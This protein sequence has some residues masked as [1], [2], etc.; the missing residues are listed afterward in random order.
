MVCFNPR[1]REERR[2]KRDDLLRATERDLERIAA[3]V[4]AGTLSGKARIGRRVGRGA[5]RWKVEKHFE[6][7]IGD[8]CISWKRRSR[9]IMDEARFDGVH[10]IRTSLHAGDIGPEAAV[11]AYKSPAR[12]E[13]AFRTVKSDLR[14]RPVY[15]YTEDHVRDCVFLCMLAY[16][17]EQNMRKRLAPLLFEDDDRQGARGRRNTPAA[18]AGPSASAE[19]KA[20]TKKTADGL[21]VHGF[22]TLLDDSSTVTLNIVSLS[23]PGR[24]KLV[25][26]TRPTELQRRA[27]KL[28][29]V[30]PK[31]PLL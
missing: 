14:I 15:V 25:V 13:R 16:Y 12:V 24:E 10:I 7:V 8:T 17:L 26:V 11:E 5:D 3:S 19:S 28:L 9:K 1:L 18:K 31:K 22:R 21:P 4:R 23:G 27:F 6:I 2:R 30:D 20:S 29:E